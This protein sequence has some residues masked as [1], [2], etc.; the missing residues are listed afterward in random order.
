MEGFQTR[1]PALSPEQTAFAEKLENG[2]IPHALIVEGPRGCG[3]RDFALW[4]ARA[5]LCTSPAH[6]PCGACAGCK[7]VQ[8]GFHPDLHLYG[9]E[10][11]IGVGDVRELIRE[12]GLVPVEGDRSVYVLFHGE[13][14]QPAAQ[15]AL[16]KI[17]EEPPSGVTILLLTESR[18]AL[19]PTVRSR[20]QRITLSGLT[21]E[22]LREELRHRE[23]QLP[24]DELDA[25]VRVARGSL[26]EA[27]DFIGKNARKQ[28][29]AARE[30]LDA[31][32]SGDAYR[33]IS[34]VAVSMSKEKRENLLPLLDGFLRML[35]DLLL[36]RT[37]EEP[38]LLEGGEA[39]SLAQRTTR[40]ALSRMC[41]RTIACRD[42]L[43]A[44]GNVTAAL[45]CLASELHAI[46]SRTVTRERAQESV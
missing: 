21:D 3:K 7:R 6:R 12:T 26:G 45:S 14:M 17:F 19:L 9:E 42:R 27:T 4:C 24:A 38:L 37:G 23:P 34:V 36:A 2:S 29:E 44:N 8:N 33:L 43:E 16:L 25:A 13:K 18:R 30:W 46:A 5:L 11:T 22:Q 1:V 28:R 31:L 35:F 32:F 20:G 41:E 15:N 39:R 40:R 10:E